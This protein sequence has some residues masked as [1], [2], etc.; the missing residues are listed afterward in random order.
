MAL[1]EREVFYQ[2]E[3]VTTENGPVAQV[4]MRREIYDT[5]TGE[6]KATQ[7]H[8]AVVPAD[9]NTVV[10]TPSGTQPL[11]QIVAGINTDTMAAKSRLETD[12]AAEREAKLAMERE[13]DQERQ[14][15]IAAE[16]RA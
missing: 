7:K 9:P 1:Q 5:V 11:S 4:C 8:R 14:R 12:L 3:I 2:M 13:R 10:T 15:R 6:V 16:A